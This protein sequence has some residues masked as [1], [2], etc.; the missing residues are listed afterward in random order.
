MDWSTWYI[1]NQRIIPPHCRVTRSYLILVLRCVFDPLRRH[2]S[3]LMTIGH[4]RNDT[5]FSFSFWSWLRWSEHLLFLST[6]INPSATWWLWKPFTLPFVLPNIVSLLF[7][8]LCTIYLFGTVAK[9]DRG[10]QTYPMLSVLNQG[11]IYYFILLLH[12]VSIKH[13]YV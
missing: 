13:S 9:L 11:H 12:V 1:S 7:W 8:T 4:V 2:F 10:V 5:L 6:K 3:H